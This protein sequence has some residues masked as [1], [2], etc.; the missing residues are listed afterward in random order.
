MKNTLIIITGPSASGKSAVAKLLSKKYKKAV[1]LDIDRVKHFVENGFIYN[2]S[3]EGKKQWKLCTNN[4][5]L[6]TKNYLKNGYVVVIEGVLENQE[7]W[8]KIFK[9]LPTLNR[10]LLSSSKKEL[11]SRNKTR[12][13][14]FI[15][16]KKDIDQHFSDFNDKFYLKYFSLIENVELDKTVESIYKICRKI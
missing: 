4:I 12:S 14:K 8:R 6:L 2:E 9:E 15:M 11:Y 1:R 5:I 7:N 13:K 16:L 3:K 10:F